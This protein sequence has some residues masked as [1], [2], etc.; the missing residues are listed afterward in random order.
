[1]QLFRKLTFLLTPVLAAQT[2]AI[3]GIVVDSSGG[4]IAGARLECAGIVTL[5][6]SD[7]RFRLPGVSECNA[8]I[9]APGFAESLTRLSGDATVRLEI[10][11]V[12]ERVLVSAA[13]AE[14]TVEEAGVAAN[15][16]TNSTF[17]QRQFPQIVDV[18]REI[19]GFHVLRTGRQGGLTQ[20]FTRGAQRTGTLVMLDG[21][22]VND[23]GGDLNFSHFLSGAVERVEAIKGPESAL[24]GAEAAAGVIQIFT[25]RGSSESRVPR[26]T[27]SY[28]RGRF[29]TD[30]WIANLSGGSGQKFDYFLSTEQFHTVSEFQN[31]FYRNTSGAANLGYRLS[32]K[33]QLRGILR[34]YDADS[35]T[36]NQT[37]Y[38]IY[39]FDAHR[40]LRDYTASVRVD[41]ARTA[42]FLQRFILGHHRVDDHYLDERSEG[43]YRIAAIVRDEPSGLA[44]PK[45][46]LVSLV[47]PDSPP[48]LMPGTRL[49]TRTTSLFAFPGASQT[50]RT[51][52]DYQGTWSQSAGATLFG[53]EYERQAGTITGSDVDRHNSGLFLHQQHSFANR[54]FLSGGARYEQN[55]VFGSKFTPRAAAS[56]RL[57]GEA[58]PLSSSFF[59]LSAG[60][61]IT[62]PSLLQSFARE[63]TYRGNPGLRPERTASY[64]AGLVQ[65]WFGRHLRTELSAFHNSFRDLI[66]FD[67][68][69]AI[70]TWQNVD[71]SRARGLEFSAQA[72]LFKHATLSGSYTRLWTRI[73]RSNAPATALGS[74][75]N[76][77][78]RRPPHSGSVTLLIAPRRWNFLGGATMMGERLDTSLLGVNRNPG[79]ANVFAGGSY[80]LSRNV[81]PFVR[82][83]NALNSRYQEVLGYSSLSRSIRGGLRLEW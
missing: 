43:P 72:R 20:V 45:T 27:L 18:L 53:Y 66:V 13:R 59:R 26:G 51:M 35:G 63:T 65:E 60:R 82:A 1:M 55:S 38:G 12:S 57:H 81:T 31:D 48:A 14:V 4:A 61:G 83:E 5:S 78:I 62:E 30:R 8:R 23:P 46:Y 80:R 49:V 40:T 41:D 67:T 25:A 69:L 7:G 2:A 75:G 39:D 52:F 73:T 29:Q 77:L 17:E 11:A 19:P 34:A 42:R 54:V 28:E 9:A 33:T 79:F 22:P 58:G 16:L 64:E 68:S 70:G 37:A 32:G 15:I 44:V 6:A 10:A 56:I 76:P 36:P 21:M 50:E 47:N 24:F 71:A 3:N 74:V